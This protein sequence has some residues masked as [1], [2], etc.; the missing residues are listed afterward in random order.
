MLYRE[1]QKNEYFT[2]NNAGT[3]QFVKYL[4]QAGL[5]DKKF[6]KATADR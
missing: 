1:M 2:G 3:L 5:L 6:N 4:R